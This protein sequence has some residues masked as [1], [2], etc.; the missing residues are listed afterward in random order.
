[1]NG[2]RLAPGEFPSTIGALGRVKVLYE[3]F[4]GWKCN[5]AKAR[6]VKELPSEAQNYIARIEKYLGVPVS[7]VGIGPAR[8]DMAVQGFVRPSDV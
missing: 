8:E 7:W 5:I 2:R 3:T 6:T 4:P 1:M